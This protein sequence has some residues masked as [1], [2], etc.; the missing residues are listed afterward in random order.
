MINYREAHKH[1]KT[2]IQALTTGAYAH[3]E[4]HI[5]T[6]HKGVHTTT[7]HTILFTIYKE[8]QALTGPYAYREAQSH[9]TRAHLQ[10]N[11]CKH[12]EAHSHTAHKARALWPKIRSR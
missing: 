5:H 7:Q 6:A 2:G 4:A 8:V 11:A 3:R 1:T 10:R 12:R 9:G